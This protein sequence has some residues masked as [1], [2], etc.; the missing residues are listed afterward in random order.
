MILLI[1][2]DY[3]F[4]AGWDIWDEIPFPVIRLRDKTKA[5]FGLGIG[6][7]MYAS[8]YTFCSCGKFLERL[9]I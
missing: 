3:F 8:E 1:I 6:M 5:A 9:F 7:S 2:F 4:G